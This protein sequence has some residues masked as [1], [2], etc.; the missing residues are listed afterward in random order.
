MNTK[1]SRDLV[2][3]NEFVQ[4]ATDMLS[5][6]SYI[7]HEWTVDKDGDHCILYFPKQSDDGFDI[8]AEVFSSE[9]IVDTDGAHFHFDH[10]KSPK[11]TVNE[12]LGLVRD[13]LSPDMRIVQKCVNN[14][15]YKW[16]LQALQNGTW[17]TE[18]N[19]AFLIFNFFGRRS[20]RV[21]TNRVLPGRLDTSDT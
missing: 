11:D 8:T 4:R 19:M 6:F 10:V 7:V 15:P 5:R 21:L 9:I 1:E 13:L 17:H 12:V 3:C 20:E 18:E 14:K 16:S 2:L